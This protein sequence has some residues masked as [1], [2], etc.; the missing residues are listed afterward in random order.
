M[1]PVKYGP[2]FKH[3][4]WVNPDAP[5]GGVVRQFAQGTFDSLNPFSMQGQPAVGINGFIY[6]ELFS[7]SPDEPT[8]QYG[9]IA[10]TVSHPADYSS[11]TFKLRKEARWHDGKPITADD[12][13][14]SLEA[15]KKAHPHYANY[16]KHIV[17]A[18]AIS[19]HEV[20]FT[21]DVKGNKE[22]PHIAGELS[23]VPKHWWTANGPDGKPR[24]L[25]KSS[26]ETPLGSGPYR[27]K[28]IDMTRGIVYERVKD[29]WAKDL[30]VMKGQWNFDEIRFTYFRDRTPAFEEFKGGK[31]DAW[32]ENRA[33]AWATQYDFDA[34]K[35][36]HVKKEQLPQSRVNGMQAFVFNIRRERFSDPRVRRALN[37][38]FNF[39]ELNKNRFYGQYVRTD[40]FFS[41]SEMAA[42]DLPQGA[43]LEILNTVKDKVPPEVFTAQ[44]KNPVNTPEMRRAN[45]AEAIKLFAAAG[46]TAQGSVLKNAKGEEFA[47]EFLTPDDSFIPLLQSYVKDLELL[48]IKATVRR[49][50][51]PQYKLREEGFD[52]DAIVETFGQSYSPGNEQRDFWGSEAAKTNGSRNLIGIAD[53]AVDELVKRVIFAK[54]RDELVAATK[55]LDRVLLWNHYVVPQW[56]YPYERLATWD[57]FGRPAKL[58]SQ[59]SS[60]LRAWWIDPAKLAAVDAVRMR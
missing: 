21:F 8:A 23:V 32:S 26:S 16:W 27:I 48:G 49:V 46:W 43:E 7:S 1:G 13:V 19:P 3:F 50:D 58:P 41:G 35:K 60:L 31:I 18:E 28:S 37:L 51:P 56:H 10:E 24:D 12:V 53:P 42:S 39:E 17:T 14:F 30:P 25:S 6:D 55:A 47:I 9:L 11:V 4:D 54:T 38:A 59:N 44:W 2:D 33:L 29:Y 45:L 5:K 34:V 15:L 52:Y 57:I 40:S 22:L 20:T 36:G